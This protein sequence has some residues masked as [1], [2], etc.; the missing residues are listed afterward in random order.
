MP[1][2][3]LVMLYLPSVSVL[4]SCFAPC[5]LTAS[6]VKPAQGFPL[7]SRICPLTDPVWAAARGVNTE[8]RAATRIAASTTDLLKIFML[9]SPFCEGAAPESPERFRPIISLVPAGFQVCLLS[10]SPASSTPCGNH[11]PIW[12]RVGGSCFRKCAQ[13]Q[14]ATVAGAASRLFL[15]RSEERRVGKECRSRLA[16]YQ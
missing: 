15:L 10:A 2:R 7:M 13:T 9:H 1:V 12:N 3:R 14:Q 6:T 5:S 4:P 8:T 11:A 16:R